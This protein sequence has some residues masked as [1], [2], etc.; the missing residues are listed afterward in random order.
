MGP[1]EREIRQ[2]VSAAVHEL[3]TPLAALSGE[4]ELALRRERTTIE[5]REALERI[6][7][8]VTELTELSADLAVLSVPSGEGVGADARSISLPQ[9]LSQ[10]AAACAA[11]GAEAVTV[12]TL[13]DGTSV[14]GSP[15]SLARGLTLLVRHAV[16]QRRPGARVRLGPAPERM[17]DGSVS[18]LLSAD[19]GGFQVGAWR[20]FEPR[21]RETPRGHA[22]GELRLRAASRMLANDGAAIAMVNDGRCEALHV[23]LPRG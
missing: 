8:R 20:Y 14:F 6:A 18:L 16:R 5:Y 17:G 23:R 1:I 15:S 7:E 13:P 9:L 10:V 19:P 21:G 22:A 2:F 4:V 3:R 11:G 12:E